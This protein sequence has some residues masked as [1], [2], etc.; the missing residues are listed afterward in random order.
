MLSNLF[1]TNGGLYLW[2]VGTS[3]K[4]GIWAHLGQFRL[5]SDLSVG[6]GEGPGSSEQG[7]GLAPRGTPLHPWLG[8]EPGCFVNA[9][10]D[11]ILCV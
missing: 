11:N 10:S 1:S 2:L 3:S 8:K 5:P 6:C 7:V 4:L 9:A